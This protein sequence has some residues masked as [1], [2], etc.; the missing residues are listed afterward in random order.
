[1]IRDQR[2]ITSHALTTIP[3]ESAPAID[4]EL[5]ALRAAG[6]DRLAQLVGDYWTIAIAPYWPAMRGV[7]EEEILVRGRTLVTE[8]TD[9]ML[10]DLG[11]RIRWE[12]PELRVPHQADLDWTMTDG[13]LIIVPV[14][15][16]RGTRVF[17]THD[18]TVAFS[19]QAQGAAVLSGHT[20]DSVKPVDEVRRR[21]RLTTLLGHGR[22]TV[23]RALLSPTTTTGLANSVGLAP[24]TVSQHLS[25]LASAGLVRR[26]RV[27][28]RV[29]YELEDS[30]VVLLT[31]LGT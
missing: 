18:D 17:S 10:R 6:H 1:V 8:G 23:L 12:S 19:Y 13:H 15:F 27:G 25:V 3:R 31:E 20:G 28:L 21:D 14:L 22:A 16:A 29:L 24:S 2:T 11:G 30:G 7:L 26:H 9:R 4:D 5:K